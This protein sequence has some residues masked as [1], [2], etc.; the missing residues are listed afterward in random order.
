MKTVIAVFAMEFIF[1]LSLM[2]PVNALDEVRSDIYNLSQREV[3][4]DG[5]NFPGFYYDI[6]DN[7]YTEKLIL[8]LSNTNLN[9]TS[10]IISDQPDAYGDRGATY[11]THAQPTE[12]DF[13]PWGQYEEIRFL[14][15]SYFAAYNSSITRI[16]TYYDQSVPFFCDM[17]GEINMM[18]NWQISKILYDDD[19]ELTISSS[20]PL[21]LYEGYKLTIKE[22]DPDGKVVNLELFKEDEIVDSKVV[23][24]SKNPDIGDETYYYSKNVGDSNDLVIIGVHFKDAFASPDKNLTTVDGIWQ[25]SE[26]PIVLDSNIKYAKMSINEINSTSLTIKMDN[27]D[28]NITLSA[29]EDIQLMDNIHIWTADQDDISP[30]NPLRYYVYRDVRR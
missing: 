25:I 20:E 4:L 2:M 1:L 10:S 29:D 19:D 23:T 22:I 11:I 9:Y 8:R 26:N 3:T 6:D 18:A 7:T 27:K 12:F 30:S 13:E 21:E 24:L 15:E 17:S 14:G 16:M 28:E 5:I